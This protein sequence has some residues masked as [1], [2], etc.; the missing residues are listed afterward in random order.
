MYVYCGCSFVQR[1]GVQAM[2]VR[3]YNMCERCCVWNCRDRIT[4]V[5]RYVWDDVWFYTT[6]DNTKEL[7]EYFKVVITSADPDAVEI[8]SPN[9][10][11]INI[12][13]NDP[14]TYVLHTYHQYNY[15]HFDSAAMLAQKVCIHVCEYHMVWVWHGWS[16]WCSMRFILYCGEYYLLRQLWS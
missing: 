16:Q 6:D 3:M 7:S 5:L 13:D 8:G 2:N 9:P 4:G 12:E 14:G 10:A 11:C 1:C 15:C